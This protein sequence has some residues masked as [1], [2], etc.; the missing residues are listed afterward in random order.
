MMELLF[1]L[2]GLVIGGLSGITVICLLKS[3][4]LSN[5]RL[6]KDSYEK[7]NN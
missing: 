5:K 2:I 3:D 7:K 6:L 4:V 1:F